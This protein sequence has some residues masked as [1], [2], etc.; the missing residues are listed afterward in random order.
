MFGAPLGD[1][2]DKLPIHGHANRTAVQRLREHRIDHVVKAHLRLC[3]ALP[4][5]E[6]C[7]RFLSGR[8]W[9]R[10]YQRRR[11]TPHAREWKIGTASCGASVCQYVLFSVVAVSLKTKTVHI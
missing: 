5:F 2:I 6:L 1:Q 9:L 8:N 10:G 11:L 4:G 3:P 7:A